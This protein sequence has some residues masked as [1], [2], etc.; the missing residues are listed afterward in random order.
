MIFTC[1]C[2]SPHD[3]PGSNIKANPKSA[4]QAVKSD[5]IKT[6]L[7][8]KSRWAMAGFISNVPDRANSSWRCVKPAVMVRAILHRSFQE[9]T[10][11]FKKS[12]RDPK[13]DFQ[14][15]IKLWFFNGFKFDTCLKSKDFSM[16]TIFMKFRGQ[17]IFHGKIFPPSFTLDEFQY[18]VMIHSGKIIYFLFCLPW[19]FV[20]H[21]KDFDGNCFT[22]LFRWIR[23]QVSHSSLPN[24]SKTAACLYFLQLN[25]P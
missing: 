9:T 13:T 3:F 11:D 10:W 4:K 17:P 24:C 21:W 25:L 12:Q 14:I 15:L 18:T 6:F 23:A 16:F 1:P 7:D 19:I 8:L 2:V 5:L 20:L 22:N